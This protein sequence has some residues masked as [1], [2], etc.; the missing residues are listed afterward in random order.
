[1]KKMSKRRQNEKGAVLFTAVAVISVL[2]ILL[3]A[4]MAFVY[5]NQNA[6]TNSYKQKQA[7]L[8]ASTT[9]ESF[10][11]QIQ[12]DTAPTSDPTAQADQKKA[13]ENLKKLADADGGK[14]TTTTVSYNGNTDNT[15][16]MGTCEITVAREGTSSANIVITCTSTYLGQTEQVAAHIATETAAIKTKY[17]NAIELTGSSGV[18]YDNLNV[19]GDMAGLNNTT[20][21]TYNFT[22]NTSIYGN[23]FM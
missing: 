22:N 9:L 2:C 14:G 7:Y 11:A 10:I 1:M 6:T 3:S 20:R 8:T 5:R 15:D 4:I 13:I 18:E 16:N 12:N 21:K 17:T 19:I 23:Y